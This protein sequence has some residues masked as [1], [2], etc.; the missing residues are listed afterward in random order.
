[1]TQAEPSWKAWT[2]DES[3]DGGYVWR[4]PVPAGETKTLHARYV[5]KI[6]SKQ[7][8]VGGNRREV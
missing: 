4:V 3:L 7:E 6:S 8:L 5:V 2:E 1:M